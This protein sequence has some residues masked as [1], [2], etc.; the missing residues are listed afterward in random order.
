MGIL[1]KLLSRNKTVDDG[2]V[3]HIHVHQQKIR[4]N[5][6]TGKREPV[7][8][9]KRGGK[10]IY[11]HEVEIDG[12]AKVVYSP[13]KPLSCGAKVWIETKAPTK[14]IRIGKSKRRKK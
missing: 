9:T 6:K 12:P 7:I 4:S 3:A 11:A 14:H 2:K 8:T 1:S 10:N 13:D 5:A